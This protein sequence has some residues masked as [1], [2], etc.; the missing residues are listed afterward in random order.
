MWGIIHIVEFIV[1][2]PTHQTANLSIP[3]V[4]KYSASPLSNL[5]FYQR[6]ASLSVFRIAEV[7]PHKVEKFRF[8]PNFF[9]FFDLS[10]GI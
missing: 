9:T 4:C 3:N 10:Q 7:K 8:P 6:P 1:T 5:L 2:V